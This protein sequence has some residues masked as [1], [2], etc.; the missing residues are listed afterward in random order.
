MK[1]EIKEFVNEIIKREGGKELGFD[2]LITDSEMDSFAYMV[3][4]M[5]LEDRFG[6]FKIMQQDIDYRTY[7]LKDI[8]EVVRVGHMEVAMVEYDITKITQ[9][10]TQ[11]VYK[12]LCSEIKEPK[13]LVNIK[14]HIR[15]AFAYKMVVEGKIQAVMLAKK[16]PAHYSLSYY[17][18][19]EDMR[20]KM[21]SLFFFLH[22]MDKLKGLPV[23]IK[24]NK[25]LSLYERYYEPCGDGIYKF[26]GLRED[27][28]WAE[29]LKR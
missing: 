6:C 11:E 27:E 17:F 7:K 8:V 19:V 29:L 18:V 13:L 23:Y 26:K 9:Q 12:L 5:E 25:N 20:K 22:S 24:A 15:H 10:D 2:D 14:N 1:H 4:W 3:L 21:P 16:F 28:T